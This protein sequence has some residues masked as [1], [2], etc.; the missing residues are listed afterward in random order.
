MYTFVRDQNRPNITNL[1]KHLYIL[2]YFLFYNCI[3]EQSNIPIF[4]KII[5]KCKYNKIFFTMM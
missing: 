5:I 4:N 1:L 3:K 2:P